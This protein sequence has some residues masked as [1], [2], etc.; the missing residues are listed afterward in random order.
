[1]STAAH[2]EEYLDSLFCEKCGYQ[3]MLGD[4][5]KNYYCPIC[6]QTGRINDAEFKE[7]LV[8]NGY[9]D[10]ADDFDEDQLSEDTDS[11]LNDDE[12]GF[13]RDES[14]LDRDESDS[15]M[16]GLGYNPFDNLDYTDED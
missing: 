10:D 5:E 1:M 16:S 2:I 14:D 8:D 13:D 12:S 3:G 15:N 7:F 9:I 11:E 6:G 4:G